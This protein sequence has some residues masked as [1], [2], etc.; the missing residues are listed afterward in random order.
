[1]SSRRERPYIS[2]PSESVRQ[3]LTAA[4]SARLLVVHEPGPTSFVLKAVDSDKKHRVFLGSVHTCSCGAGAASQPCEHTA[5]VLIRVFR[6]GAEDSRVWQQ[7]MLDSELEKL[8]EDRA[9]S[10]ALLRLQARRDAR[11]GGDEYSSDGRTLASAALSGQVARRPIDED[12]GEPCPICY[13]D[14]MACEEEEEGLDWCRQGCGKSVHRSCLKVWADHQASIAKSLSCPFCRCSWGEP[15]PVSRAR[16]GGLGPSA[17]R[18]RGGRGAGE[19]GR[20]RSAAP[21]LTRWVD[22]KCRSCR[23][24]PIY[25]TLYRCLV[26]VDAPGERS[27]ELCS[28]CFGSGMHSHHPCGCRAKPSHPW[29]AAPERVPMQQQLLPVGHDQ[30]H[31]GVP[32]HEGAAHGAGGAPSVLQVHTHAHARTRRAHAPRARG[33]TR[34]RAHAHTHTHT[35]TRTHAHTRTHTRTH[36]HTHTH[37]HTRGRAHAHTH[38]PRARTHTHARAHERTHTHTHTHTR[39][40]THIYLYLSIYL[41]IHPSIYL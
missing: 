16:A 5:F 31:G 30:P 23:S 11:E 27:V 40:H 34:A 1:M 37:T 12:E 2:K 15:A 39:A 6:L 29:V 18:E 14:I 36:T 35:H 8:I 26:C 13:E 38:T 22:A 3:R 33:H 24:S 28:D 25:G 32:P 4:A 19:G 17:R 9:R 10:V 7:S 21:R 41:S 20:G